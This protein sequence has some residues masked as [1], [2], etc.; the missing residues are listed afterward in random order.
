MSNF[1]TELEYEKIP[2]KH[3]WS[4]QLY[5]LTAPFRY[6][7]GSED[8]TD[9][10]EAET[11]FVLDF[12]STPWWI[13]WLYPPKGW[14]AKPAVIHD[15][16]HSTHGFWRMTDN[17]VIW[18]ECSREDS[19]NWLKEGMEVMAHFIDG[20]KISKDKQTTI[21]RFYWAVTNFGK[22]AWEKGGLYEM[23]K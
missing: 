18:V 22:K 23:I 5:V 1:T 9:Y 16:T 7:I 4:K 14:Y 3:F 19:D 17:G 13:W 11:G 6:Y 2:K 10:V 8:S 15:K 21:D 20:A 12:A